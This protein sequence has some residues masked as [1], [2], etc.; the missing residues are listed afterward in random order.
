MQHLVRKLGYSLLFIQILSIFTVDPHSQL[1]INGSRGNQFPII[2]SVRQGCPLS[3]VLFVIII[4][5]LSK[6]IGSEQ[7]AS[8]IT[9]VSLPGIGIAYVQSTST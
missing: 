5:A 1:L 7:S 6:C 3:T 8:T 2:Y 9:C 4:H